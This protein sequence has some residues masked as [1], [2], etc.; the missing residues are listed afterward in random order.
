[1]DNLEAGQVE[2]HERMAR[3][4]GLLE[5]LRQA[6]NRPTSKGTTVPPRNCCEAASFYVC[7]LVQDISGTAAPWRC[8]TTVSAAR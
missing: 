7:N 3:P 5:G 1:M 4:E 8:C 6:R 2:L